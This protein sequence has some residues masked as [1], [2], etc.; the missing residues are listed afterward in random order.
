MILFQPN[1]LRWVLRFSKQN[2]FVIFFFSNTNLRLNS[3]AFA[4]HDFTL[5]PINGE[6][7][8][9][10]SLLLHIR[11]GSVRRSTSAKVTVR[12]V[13]LR[14]SRQHPHPQPGL[15]QA[16]IYHNKIFVRTRSTIELSQIYIIYIPRT[17]HIISFPSR[18]ITF[19]FIC[20]NLRH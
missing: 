7:G 20:H 12:R 18:D 16:E 10:R 11:L 8:P 13:S 2:L 14:H 6:T 9:K 5:Y 19:L 15:P 17:H 1:F 3:L 4:L